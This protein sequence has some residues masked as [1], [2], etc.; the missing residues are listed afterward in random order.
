[1][2]PR[3]Y[4]SS[5]TYHF[6]CLTLPSAFCRCPRERVGSLLHQEHPPRMA[7][8]SHPWASVIVPIKDE[9]DNLAPLIEGLLAVMSSHAASKTRPFELIFVD[10]GSSDGSSEGLD[11]GGE[12]FPDS[13]L[14]PRSKIWQDLRARSG[15]QSVFRI[16]HP[17]K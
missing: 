2:I 17:F 9:R 13:G 6:L 10:D 7:V 12:S 1:M 5:L 11:R 14:P 16:H 3:P 8:P 15:F 4:S